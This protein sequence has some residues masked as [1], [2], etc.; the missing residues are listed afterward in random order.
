MLKLQTRNNLITAREDE[1]TQYRQKRCQLYPT[2]FSLTIPR[3]TVLRT[4]KCQRETFTCS[5]TEGDRMIVIAFYPKYTGDGVCGSERMHVC[6][7]QSSPHGECQME[8][9]NQEKKKY[10]KCS[11]MFFYMQLLMIRRSGCNKLQTA[12]SCFLKRITCL[13]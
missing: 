11:R 1:M 10:H 4:E 13:N 9:V 2:F 12:V 8:D 3:M 7:H 6:P 5:R